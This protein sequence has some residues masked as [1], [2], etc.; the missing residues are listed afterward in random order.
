MPEPTPY[1]SQCLGERTRARVVS[2]ENRMAIILKK[3]GGKWWSSKREEGKD[4]GTGQSKHVSVDWNRGLKVRI[5]RTICVDRKSTLWPRFQIKIKK[6]QLEGW[7]ETTV[8]NNDG[9][10]SIVIMG[11]AFTFYWN[12]GCN[13]EPLHRTGVYTRPTPKLGR[14]NESIGELCVQQDSNCI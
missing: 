12:E 13:T 4:R 9:A 14:K 3:K 5:V 1:I 7:G 2:V 11:G 8:N 6:P 10:H